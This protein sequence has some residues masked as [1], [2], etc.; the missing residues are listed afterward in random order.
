M[1]LASITIEAMPCRKL[2]DHEVTDSK[3]PPPVGFLRGV[4]MSRAEVEVA[5][6]E[7]TYSTP[8]LMAVDAFQHSAVSS[9]GRF[10]SLTPNREGQGGPRRTP[11]KSL[12]VV[13]PENHVVSP[14]LV[15]GRLRAQGDYEMDVILAYA[16]QSTS[17]AALQRQVRDLQVLEAPA[18]TSSEDLRELAMRQAPGDIVTLLCGTPV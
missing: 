13:L 1:R 8:T 3:T 11:R 9:A 12:I 4:V 7:N 16:G 10:V 15:A 6:V 2:S 14:D 18:G 17:I 5:L